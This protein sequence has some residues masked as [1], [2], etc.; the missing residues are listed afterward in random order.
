MV[1]RAAMSAKSTVV[2]F[3]LLT[4]AACDSTPKQPAAPSGETKAATAQATPTPAKTTE[5]KPTDTMNVYSLSLKTLEGEK[6]DL[7][8]Y[9]GKVTLLVNVASQ[10]GYTPQYQGL[11]ALH[12]ELKDKGFAV[13]GIPCN[14]FGAQEPGT[15]QD[16]RTFCT[17]KYKVDF[18]MFEKLQTKAGNGQSELYATLQKATGKLPNWNFCKYLVGKDGK[19]IQFYASGTAPDSKELRAAIESALK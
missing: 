9:A 3:S 4:L 10:C 17:T 2:L 5:T 15:A 16:I 7:S 12:T 13:L 19:V 11:Q 8:Q 1:E 6:A 18:P 14:D